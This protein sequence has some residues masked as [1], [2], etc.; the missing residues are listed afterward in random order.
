MPNKKIAADALAS[1]L[2][3]LSH[4]S[5]LR[6]VEELGLRPLD[7]GELQ[8]ILET[9]HSVVSRQLG[10]LRAHHLVTERR[11]GRHV[12]Y[13]LVRP[14]IAKWLVEGLHYVGP[15]ESETAALQEAVQKARNDWGRAPSLQTKKRSLRAPKPTK[16]SP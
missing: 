5:R 10:L 15:I 8:S 9:S 7:V 3:V 6:I 13:R 14:G 4:P 16:V 1:L 2:A 12:E 11:L